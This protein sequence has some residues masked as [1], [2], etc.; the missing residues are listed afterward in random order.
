[1]VTVRTGQEDS[2]EDDPGTIASAYYRAW[3]EKDFITLR[4]LLADG[5]TFL[6]P[7]GRA[8]DADSCVQGLQ[9]MSQIVTDIVIHKIFVDGPDAST[10]FDLHTSVAPPCPTASW[11]HVEE[12]KVASIRA[13]FDPRPLL[14]P[15]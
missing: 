7:L 8:D 9:G 4:S 10:W 3:R 12:G 1:L 2:V 6:G 13:T 14:P 5:V 15:S 11:I